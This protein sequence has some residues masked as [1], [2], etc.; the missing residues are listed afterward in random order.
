MGPRR[1]RDE[2][3]PAVRV[4]TKSTALRLESDIAAAGLEAVGEVKHMHPAF[5]ESLSEAG[6][7]D[8]QNH[9]KRLKFASWEPAG[10]K[11]R[12]GG[13]DV[14]V[15]CAPDY[16]AVFE[17]K[18]AWTKRELGWTLWDIYK[19]AA[20]RIEFDVTAYVVV[21]APLS[22]WHDDGVA[23]SS[24]YC[25][26]TWDSQQLFRRYEGAWKDL[27]AGGAARPGRIPARITTR[28]I[29]S[30]LLRIT[31]PWQLR[32]L[33]IEIPNGGWLAFEEGWPWSPS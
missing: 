3:D 26:A 13:V 1:P 23:C 16:R 11:G 29:A 24:L 19:M 14:I 17:L 15:G 12:L 2:L 6:L 10:V 5:R 4:A 9:E 27:L 20:A 8:V 31:P 18:W 7:T 25:D 30:E 21:G 22:Y 32:A 28:L 33:R